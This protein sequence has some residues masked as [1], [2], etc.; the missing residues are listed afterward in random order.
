MP[1]TDPK[2]QIDPAAAVE[3]IE[4]ALEELLSK[5]PGSPT[6]E[7]QFALLSYSLSEWRWNAA[8]PA[9]RIFGY[10]LAVLVL[11]KAIVTQSNPLC[12]ICSL[13][14][15]RSLR[16]SDNWVHT[17]TGIALGHVFLPHFASRASQI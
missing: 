8:H 7:A 15:R 12:E 13:R 11:A 5:L 6:L 9:T 1:E 4:E 3:T 16:G 2:T 14:I 10:D 17:D